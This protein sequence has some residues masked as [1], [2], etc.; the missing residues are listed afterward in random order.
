MN[1]Q[2]R[3]A[4]AVLSAVILTATSLTLEATQ[5]PNNL[6]YAKTLKEI[7]QEKKD[8]QDQIDKKKAE[9]KKLAEDLSDK[10]AYEQTLKEEINL[11]NGK[12]VLID[13]QMSNLIGE[14]S[15]KEAEIA[16]LQNQI[17]EEEVAVQ[18][19]LKAFKSRIRALYVHG[20]DSLL[21]ALVGASSFYDVLARIDLIKR[22]SKHDD[23]M[24][25]DLRE[26]I[27]TLTNHKQDLTASVQA[28]N[29]KQTEI[30]VLLDEFDASK[31][32]LNTA[33]SDNNVEI[34]MI[35]NKQLTA[36]S[37][38]KQQEMDLGEIEK[39]QEAIIAE[40]LRKAMEEEKKQKEEEERRKAELQAKLT[41]TVTT[42]TTTTIRTTTTT[43]AKPVVYTTAVPT[44]AVTEPP[45]SDAQQVAP[46]PVVTEATQPPVT[47]APTAPPTTAPTAAPTTTATTVTVPAPTGS[48]FAWP[49]PG[50]YGISSYFGPRPDPFG[51]GV[52]KGHG[53][54]DIIGNV[55]PINGAAVCAAGNG[56]VS[57]VTN[58]N[59]G[60]GYGKHVIIYHGNG[61]ATLYAHMQ[62][63]DVS[64]GQQVTVGTQLGLVGMTGSA[65]GPHLH[66]EVRINNER[67]NP[68]NYLP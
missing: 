49:V 41:T 32:E 56:T 58:D 25:T 16:D 17:D 26:E 39:E 38:L 40:V 9:L 12:M 51:S 21:S 15:D 13:S 19:G 34:Q 64:V 46:Q 57:Y 35:E 55:S 50:H 68:L 48:M 5:N 29:I 44:P 45:A 14:I 27:Q 11:I 43:T 10:S 20:N 7:E 28:L 62:R 54:I 59:W 24:I 22:I 18:E 63:V 3:K 47:A 31:L 60:G 2:C 61:Y 36:N 33:L 8:K 1:K 37:E 53:A 67:V 65:T 30:Q 42:T 52:I 66:F 6:T 23:E 4:L